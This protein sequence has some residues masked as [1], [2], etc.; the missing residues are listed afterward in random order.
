MDDI[1]KQNFFLFK[2]H[3]RTQGVHYQIQYPWLADYNIFPE[4]INTCINHRTRNIYCICSYL[5]LCKRCKCKLSA[6]E[7]LQF[8][9]KSKSPSIFA[10][11]NTNLISA[12]FISLDSTFK[13]QKKRF[14]TA[15]L[16]SAFLRGRSFVEKGL[17][18]PQHE[19]PPSN[20]PFPQPFHHRLH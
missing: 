18:G 20:H 17:Q 7:S 15:C 8:L 4:K 19:E 2:C 3:K 16:N 1:Y 11:L 13:E 10:F 9:S 6:K 14:L 5:L 12:G